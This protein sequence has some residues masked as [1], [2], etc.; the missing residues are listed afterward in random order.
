MR[1]S[2]ISAVITGK[3][4]P[5]CELTG[6]TTIHMAQLVY[7]HQCH[8]VWTYG[9]SH[10]KSTCPSCSGK[11]PVVRNGEEQRLEDITSEYELSTEQFLELMERVRS[12][13]L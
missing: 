1:A 8:Y 7:C 13:E 4:L 9:G 2:Q 11:V 5:W 10:L 6:T 3:N 12:H